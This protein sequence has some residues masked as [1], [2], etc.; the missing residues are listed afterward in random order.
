MYANATSG[1]MDYDKCS[2]SAKDFIHEQ[3]E[4]SY[5]YQALYTVRLLGST[6]HHDRNGF[7]VHTAHIDWTVHKAVRTPLRACLLHQ[8]HCPSL[9]GYRGERRLYH[10]IRK[11]YYR[12]HQ[13]NETYMTVRDFRECVRN[14][15]SEK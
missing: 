12:P 3:A 10:S 11:E 4:D 7:S 1:E 14:K 8:S 5:C 13:E 9:A 2:I 6:S 15:Q